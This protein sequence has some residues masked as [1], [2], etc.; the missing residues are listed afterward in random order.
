MDIITMSYARNRS[1]IE[2]L[3]E[4]KKYEPMPLIGINVNTI[5]RI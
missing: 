1:V 4:V 3:Q 2:Y 5:N